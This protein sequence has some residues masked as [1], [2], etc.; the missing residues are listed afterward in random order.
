MHPLLSR[1]H[2]LILPLVL[3][4]VILFEELAAYQ[5]RLRVE[6]PI[7]RTLAI[8]LLYGPVIGAA[9]AVISPRLKRLFIRLRTKS[10]QG[11]GGWGIASFFVVSYALVFYAY[12]LLETRGATALLPAWTL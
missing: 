11:A 9:A 7:V 10:R 5:L 1:S 8:L 3:L 6:N 4:C 12:F 2:V